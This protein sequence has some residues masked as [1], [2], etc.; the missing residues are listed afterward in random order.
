VALPLAA[1]GAAAGWYARTLIFGLGGPAGNDVRRACP[2]CART[3]LPWRRPLL[4]GLSASGRCPW[5][6]S[7]IGPRP[8]ATEAGAAAVLGVA[9]ARVSPALV[10]AAASWLALCAVPAAFIDWADH[11]LPDRLTAAAYAG[12]MTFLAAAAAAGGQW[13]SLARAVLG[14]AAMGGL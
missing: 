5:C 13:A 12:T 6:R 1:D 4:A 7:R 10:L 14:G 2:S 9:V 8:G 11:R 3:V